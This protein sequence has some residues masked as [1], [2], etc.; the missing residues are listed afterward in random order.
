MGYER[1]VGRL[2]VSP[3]GGVLCHLQGLPIRLCHVIFVIPN[4]YFSAIQYVRFADAGSASVACKDNT[5][6]ASSTGHVGT[7]VPGTESA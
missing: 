6:T 1:H 4:A 2:L 7:T 3:I 5:R